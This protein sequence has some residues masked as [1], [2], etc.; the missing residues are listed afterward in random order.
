MR[1]QNRTEL[2]EDTCDR[3]FSFLTDAERKCLDLV[4]EGY[5]AKEIARRH[6]ISVHSVNKIVREIR[7]RLGPLSNGVAVTKPVLARAYRAWKACGNAPPNARQ[8][9]GPYSSPLSQADNPGSHDLLAHT[10]NGPLAEERAHARQPYLSKENVAA[11][12]NLA[13]FPTGNRP[14]N[15]AN[16]KSALVACAI[17]ACMTMIAAGSTTSFLAAIASLVRD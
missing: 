9:I 8:R 15:D 4:A 17:I 5:L 7:R 13:P 10:P 14:N 1:E 3:C 11:S 2:S 12:L 6:D 16:W